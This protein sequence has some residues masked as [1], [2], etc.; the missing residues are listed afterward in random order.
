MGFEMI[1][2]QHIEYALALAERFVTALEVKAAA[3]ARLAD[4]MPALIEKLGRGGGGRGNWGKSG[5]DHGLFKL[6]PDFTQFPENDTFQRV[7]AY[8]TYEDRNSRIV[9]YTPFDKDGNLMPEKKTGVVAGTIKIGS[10][11]WDKLFKDWKYS[12]DGQPHAFPLR[13]LV[14]KV[15]LGKE[16]KK[17]FAYLDAIIDPGTGD[18]DTLTYA[19]PQV[20]NASQP[21]GS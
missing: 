21:T 11:T 6:Q 14:M 20:N 12:T 15:G 3:D 16:D 13:L 2:T 9:F 8:Y 18:L 10:K 1:T 17:P 4:S 19:D 5:A 7:A